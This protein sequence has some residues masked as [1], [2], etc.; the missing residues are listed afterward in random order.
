MTATI[1]SARLRSSGP[2]AHQACALLSVRPS[3]LPA[4]VP[5]A[6]TSRP[7]PQ[8]PVSLPHPAE[9]AFSIQGEDSRAP[10][11]KP[12][13]LRDDCRRASTPARRGI[14][15]PD[16]LSRAVWYQLPG[17][18]RSTFVGLHLRP[19]VSSQIPPCDRRDL[20]AAGP[21]SHSPENSDNGCRPK[22]PRP[23]LR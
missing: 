6:L 17:S 15:I 19:P 14:G 18:G 12:V 11:R 2:A 1:I 20:A 4:T 23:P 3:P 10:D 13:W 22:T 9:F 5:S 16:P 21:R 7:R 8:P